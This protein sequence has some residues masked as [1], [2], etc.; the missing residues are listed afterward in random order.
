MGGRSRPWPAAEALSRA[1]VSTCS[2]N[3]PV[4]P[5]CPDTDGHTHNEAVTAQQ[6]CKEL[7]NKRGKEWPVYIGT[8]SYRDTDGHTHCEADTAQQACQI[9][10]VIIYISKYLRFNR[11][12]N[13]AISKTTPSRRSH[14][15]LY[16]ES[17]HI[18]YTTRE[19]I[20]LYNVRVIIHRIISY[21]IL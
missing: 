9:F 19:R 17:Y 14:C 5:S 8:A 15:S 2:A 18:L 7:G 10:D 11:P 16:T 3:L 12:L 1:V 4:A 13:R 6:A 21:P 20:I